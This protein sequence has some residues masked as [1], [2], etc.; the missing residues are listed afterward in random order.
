MSNSA[1]HIRKL[2][3]IM[4]TDARKNQ[5]TKLYDFGGEIDSGCLIINKC[6]KGI[7]H[8]RLE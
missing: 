1:W 5:K 3:L 7:Y 2:H 8:Y 6:L 4:K